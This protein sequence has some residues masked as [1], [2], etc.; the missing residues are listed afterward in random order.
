MYDGNID[1]KEELNVSVASYGTMVFGKCAMLPEHIIGK[2][3]K[4]NGSISDVV[5]VTYIEELN[6]AITSVRE[7]TEYPHRPYP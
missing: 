2:E 4:V 3:S 1:N 6:T 5:D 7:M